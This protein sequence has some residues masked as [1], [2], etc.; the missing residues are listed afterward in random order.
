M[1]SPTIIEDFKQKQEKTSSIEMLRNFWYA[2][3]PANQI[4][5]GQ[6]R[7]QILLNVPL[8]VCRDNKGEVFVLDDHCPHRGIP[9]SFGKFD[10]SCVECCYHGWQFDREG[11]CQHIPALL[12]DSQIKIDRIKA[13]SFRSA[14][15]DG[16]IWVFMPAQGPAISAIPE[17]PRLPLHSENY[18]TCSISRKLMCDVD[19]GIVGLMD[20]AH[21]PFVHQSFWWRSRKSIHAKSKQFEPIPNGF[22]MSAHKP[23]KNSGAYKLLNIYGDAISTTIDFVLPNVRIEQIRCGNYWFSSRTLVTPISDDECR[24]D[25][26][27]AWNILHG[28]PFIKSIFKFF[29]HWFV[30]QDQRIMEKQSIGLKDNPSLMLI[31]DA[32]T[33]AKWYYKL[34]AAYLESQRTGSPMEHPIKTPVTLQWRS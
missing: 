3:L 22:R 28:V 15:A 24:L 11:R 25:I 6:M 12:P 29:A 2:P 8:L 19:H 10:G 9:L 14:E 33:Q 16:Y 13:K 7:R 20:P 31:D 4:K 27:A 26:S 1:S 5:P 32:D 21:G 34:K 18:R 30:G 23:S 17:I